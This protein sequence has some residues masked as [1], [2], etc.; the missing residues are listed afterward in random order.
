MRGRRFM[1]VLLLV[2]ILPV[3]LQDFCQTSEQ[4]V[5]E[6]EILETGLLQTE[7]DKQ[8]MIIRVLHKDKIIDLDI[9][10]YI[11]SVL[12]AEMP[13]SFEKEALKAQAVAI[14]TYTL[15]KIQGTQKHLDADICTYNGCCQ[16]YKSL[17][18]VED[19]ESVKK[20][21]NAV[22]DTRSEVIMYDG[23]LIDATYFSSSGGRTESAA[24][25]WGVNVPYLQAK[26]SPEAADTKYYRDQISYN[27]SELL[28][29]LG[30]PGSICDFTYEDITYTDGY[31]IDTINICGMTFT[32][33]E[34]RHLLNLRSTAF[35][36]K[37]DGDTITFITRGYGHRVGLSQY[38]AQSMAQKGNNYRQILAYYYPDT[39]LVVLPIED[40]YTLFDK[41]RFL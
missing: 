12:I 33:V 32:G 9:D 29:I 5:I 37:I 23:E 7:E 34:L 27:E 18:E 20:V 10:D 3:V 13:A 6:E 16:A 21:E 39:E 4:R 28:S 15:H 8:E 22:M 17:D 38:G 35:D 25:V 1:L 24:A 14:R 2:F 26:D 19:I 41:E 40:L 30:F 11:S 31:G 36:I